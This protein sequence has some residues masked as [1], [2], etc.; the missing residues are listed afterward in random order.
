MPELFSIIMPAFNSEKTIKESIESVLSQTVSQFRLYV[1]NDFSN[2]KTKEIINGF[3]DS[4][5]VYLEN[6]KNLGVCRSRNR[7]LELCTGKYIAFL[8][9]DD[10]WAV[11]KLEEHFSFL[12]KGWL[13]VYSN[14][15]TFHDDPNSVVNIRKSPEIISYNDL[16]KSNF[17]GNLTG[18]YNASA[19]GKI[20]QTKKGHED[21]IM[22]L[23]LLA[24]SGK[25]YCIQKELA[26]YRISAGTISSNKFQTIIWQW[27]I[28]RE[29][30]KLPF[31]SAL[32]YFLCY[33]YYGITKR[34]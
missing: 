21:Y 5:I 12:E 6:D 33:L 15:N 1:I 10:V 7:A 23:E 2:D 31:V 9:S 22:W 20:Y 28:Y 19:L 14:Y 17:I 26:S 16:L 29:H 32:Y 3:N 30:L 25:A 27:N 8:D 34:I 24:K 18:T 4:R 11:N 13:V